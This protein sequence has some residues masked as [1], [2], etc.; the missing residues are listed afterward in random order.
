MVA[1]R[2][3]KGH[4]LYV[5]IPL[6]MTLNKTNCYWLLY[7][8]VRC[9]LG[10]PLTNKSCHRVQA[11]CCQFEGLAK[12]T[13]YNIQLETIWQFSYD[14]SLSKDFPPTDNCCSLNVFLFFL[15]V[16]ETLRSSAFSEIL[17]Q[18]HL[19]PTAMPLLKSH[20]FHILK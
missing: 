20:F 19:I 7:M 8:L 12:A 4:Q 11:F 13:L 6:N 5:F 3:V 9:P 16:C 1:R 18:V 17:K 14:F 15:V 10:W 2:S